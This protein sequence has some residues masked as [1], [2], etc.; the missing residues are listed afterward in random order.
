MCSYAVCVPFGMQVCTIVLYIYLDC[1]YHCRAALRCAD[2]VSKD[3]ICSLFE[4]K[5]R[6]VSAELRAIVLARGEPK[7][8]AEI[9]ALGGRLPTK[10]LSQAASPYLVVTGSTAPSNQSSRKGSRRSARGSSPRQDASA[11]PVTQQAALAA[12]AARTQSSALSIQQAADMLQQQLL[13]PNRQPSTADILQL[14]C[15]AS[16]LGPELRAFDPALVNSLQN[17]LT[18]GVNADLA[19]DGALWFAAALAQ[20]RLVEQARDSPVLAEIVAGSGVL[21]DEYLRCGSRDS[22]FVRVGCPVGSCVVRLAPCIDCGH[23]CRGL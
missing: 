17:I 1:M 15:R 16:S 14:S 10:M 9:Q 5:A 6:L 22:M 3:S 8:A 21:E 2:A 12:A 19:K 7:R 11:A 13:Q 20:L 18:D 23:C 4:A